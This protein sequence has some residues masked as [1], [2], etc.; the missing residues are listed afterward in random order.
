MILQRR[1]TEP[2]S[3]TKVTVFVY[4]PEHDF[5]ESLCL[6]KISILFLKSVYFKDFKDSYFL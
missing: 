5:S 3:K 1:E 4:L 6:I 2:L